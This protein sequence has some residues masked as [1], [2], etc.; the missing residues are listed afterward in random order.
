ML[1]PKAEKLDLE[2]RPD[3]KDPDFCIAKPVEMRVGTQ[4]HSLNV[5]IIHVECKSSYVDKT[6]LMSLMQTAMRIKQGCASAAC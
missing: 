4:T 1:R 3:L 5:P 6:M 2:G